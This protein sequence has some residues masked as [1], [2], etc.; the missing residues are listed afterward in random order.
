MPCDA[1]TDRASMMQAGER[2]RTTCDSRN[3][4]ELSSPANSRSVRSRPRYTPGSYDGQIV[5]FRAADDHDPREM[6]LGL[7]SAGLEV[8]DMPGGHLDML[9]EPIVQA[10]ASI[11]NG[12][13]EAADRLVVRAACGVGLHRPLERCW[14]SDSAA[15]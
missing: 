12:H 15:L 6:W 5:L 9:E 8:H 7:S 11:V 14:A 1:Q 2:L 13:L 4:V 3:P 10:T